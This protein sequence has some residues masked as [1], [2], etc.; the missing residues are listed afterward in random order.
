MK[1]T[2]EKAL[3]QETWVWRSYVSY[4]GEQGPLPLL[5]PL[6]PFRSSGKGAFGEEEIASFSSYLPPSL[7]NLSLHLIHHLIDG[8]IEIVVPS[9]AIE[10]PSIPDN[11]DFGNM[12]KFFYRQN[13]MNLPRDSQYI[14]EASAL[15]LLHR[16]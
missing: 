8:G 12:P 9:L 4:G 3:P 2:I 16:P 14:F 11:G 15:S 5:S 10:S 13:D 1:G 6:Q 7:T